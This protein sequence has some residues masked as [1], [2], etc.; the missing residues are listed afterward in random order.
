ME[1][2]FKILRYILY[3]IELLVLFILQGTPNLIPELFGGKPNLLFPAVLTIS[4]F[5]PKLPALFF[6]LAG[7]LLTDIGNGGIIGFFAIISVIFCYFTSHLT[8][9]IIRTSLLTA[10]IITLIAI[11]ITIGLH[12]LFFYILPGY[13]EVG[14]FFIN[15]YLSR[16]LYTIVITPILYFINRNLA[17][18]ISTSE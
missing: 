1:Q 11:P 14:Y 6:G 10:M 4:M 2:R 16:I 5:E 15:H 3:G 17:L 7:G 12:F 13:G 9:E 18:R 8:S